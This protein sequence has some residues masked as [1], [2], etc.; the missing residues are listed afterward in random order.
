MLF[1][2]C[3]FFV[4]TCPTWRPSAK[5]MSATLSGSGGNRVGGVCWAASELSSGQWWRREER[6]RPPEE[7]RPLLLL[8]RRR[9]TT[10][11]QTAIRSAITARAVPREARRAAPGLTAYSSQPLAKPDTKICKI[12]TIYFRFGAGLL[13]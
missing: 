11:R 8:R 9:H 6:W 13:K 7:E 10:A 3:K 2:K 1:A 12:I 5:A 4:L